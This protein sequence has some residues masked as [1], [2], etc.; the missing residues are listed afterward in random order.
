M[1]SRHCVGLRCHL[2]LMCAYAAML[3]LR[4]SISFFFTSML[5][6]TLLFLHLKNI[7][8]TIL[9]LSLVYNAT[10]HH[11]N[12]MSFQ[13]SLPPVSS[14]VRRPDVKPTGHGTFSYAFGW[15]GWGLQVSNKSSSVSSLST[16]FNWDHHNAFGT[17]HSASAI[18]SE[19]WQPSTK[20]VKSQFSK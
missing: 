5:I 13:R 16:A 2:P 7:W 1:Y 10:R 12:Y 4:R 3:L 18:L 8:Y 6:L 17:W 19:P 11:T 20:E 9:N 15:V 14:S